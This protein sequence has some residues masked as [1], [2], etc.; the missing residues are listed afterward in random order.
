MMMV[1][2]IPV[3]GSKRQAELTL[4]KPSIPFTGTSA[5]EELELWSRRHTAEKGARHLP[6]VEEKTGLILI[7]YKHM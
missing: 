4:K 6:W 5:L 3:L 7:I 2:I 1:P